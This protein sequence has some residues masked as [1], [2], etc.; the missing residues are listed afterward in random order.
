MMFGFYA[1]LYIK[2]LF[3]CLAN[4]VQPCQAADFSGVFLGLAGDGDAGSV[5]SH[6]CV[7]LFWP[8]RWNR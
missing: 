4:T 7:G 3:S 5:F 1:E 8:W 6:P 2:Y